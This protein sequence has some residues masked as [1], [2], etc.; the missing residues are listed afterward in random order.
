[1]KR[2]LSFLL[3]AAVLAGPSLLQAAPT[4]EDLIKEHMKALGGADAYKKIKTRQMK[5]V[6]DIPMQGISAEMV[7][8]SKAPDKQRT[9]IDIPGMGKVVEGCDGKT[10]WS[11]NPWTGLMDKTG[12]QLKQAQQQAEFYRDIELLTRYTGWTLKGKETIDGKST[13]V[14]EGKTK[15]G[16]V[17]TLFLDEKTHLLVQLKAEV[18]SEQGR[19]TVVSKLSDYRDVDGI[20]MP[21]SIKIEAG[22]GGFNMT[23]KEIK[24]GLALDDKLFSKPA[25]Q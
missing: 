2:I 21:H 14:L 5:G 10:A 22:P 13:D 15:E 23:V 25:A 20:K 24:H 18:E 8:M 1:M 11:Q 3:A 19:M 17:D 16:T 7:I 6:I 12:A 4:A 9:E